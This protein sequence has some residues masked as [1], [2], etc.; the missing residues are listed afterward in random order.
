LRAA[1]PGC[2]DLSR[3][4]GGFTPHL[5]VGQAGSVAEARQLLGHLQRVW[6]PIRFEL[7]AVALIRRDPD[8]PF[9]IDRHI[10]LAAA[11]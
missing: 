6:Q 1:C 11:P 8:G 4:P 2:D 9:E 3:Y 5:S 7:T 10:P